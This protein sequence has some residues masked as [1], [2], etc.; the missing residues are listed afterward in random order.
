MKLFQLNTYGGAGSTGRIA[1]GISRSLAQCGGESH[2]GFGAGSATPDAEPYALRIGT[3]WERKVHGA[4]RKLLD[5]KDA[6]VRALVAKE[7]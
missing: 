7:A 2:I 3:P 6:A 5:A 1:L 4:L